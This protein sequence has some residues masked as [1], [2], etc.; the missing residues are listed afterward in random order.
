MWNY[1]RPSTVVQVVDFPTTK[2]LNRVIVIIRE[3]EI[4]RVTLLTFQVQLEVDADSQPVFQDLI[5][6]FMQMWGMH[7]LLKA[8]YTLPIRKSHDI[9]EYRGGTGLSGR[10]AMCTCS[11]YYAPIAVPVLLPQKQ[12]QL[13]SC[14]CSLIVKSECSRKTIWSLRT[15]PF[16][17]ALAKPVKR[18][19]K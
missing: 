19:P 4:L 16:S 10:S 18:C 8:M 17:A 5:K 9:Q 2:D 13:W 15:N 11:C 14:W 1:D 3:I 7:N 6:S 12:S